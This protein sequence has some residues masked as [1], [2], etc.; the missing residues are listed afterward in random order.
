MNPLVVLLMVLGAGG[1][2]YK[3]NEGKPKN[4]RY[5]LN[6]P[7]SLDS[8]ALKQLVFNTAQALGGFMI[9]AR[10]GGVYVVELPP[11]ALPTQLQNP[12]FGAAPQI[13][14]VSG[15]PPIR[16][17]LTG[18]FD[19]HLA[20]N[21]RTLNPV[22]DVY[23]QPD[24]RFFDPVQSLPQWNVPTIKIAGQ[25]WDGTTISGPTWKP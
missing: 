13:T 15:E 12:A 23:L 3:V 18:E 4:I 17:N 14:R 11:F 6:F 24:G 21:Y 22:I 16:P 5:Q 9:D 1:I 20:Q 19:N 25:T 10:G 7:P 2:Y 8:E